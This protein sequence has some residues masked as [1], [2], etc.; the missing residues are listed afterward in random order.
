[1]ILGY[2]LAIFRFSSILL[3]KGLLIGSLTFFTGGCRESASPT[4]ATSGT[5]T[6]TATLTGPPKWSYSVTTSGNNNVV[7]IEL[8]T[9]VFQADCTFTNPSGWT[10]V[11]SANS[12]AINNPAKVGTKTV[13]FSVS[14]PIRNGPVFIKITDQGGAT[15]TLG[16]IDGPVEGGV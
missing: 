12:L 6:V 1:M 9:S 8:K 10:A 14:C 13:E 15:A 5:F 7:N 4:T 2:P 16:P 11:T 3:V